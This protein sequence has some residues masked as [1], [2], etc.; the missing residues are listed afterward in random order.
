MRD[1]ER[2][3]LVFTP[4]GDGWLASHAMLPTPLVLADRIRIF[5]AA[6]DADLRQRPYS[7]A[8]ISTHATTHTRVLRLRSTPGCSILAPPGAFDGDGVKSKPRSFVE[9]VSSFLY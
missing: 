7:S 1:W 9:T 5:F 3:G 6:C 2:R 4:E 8:S